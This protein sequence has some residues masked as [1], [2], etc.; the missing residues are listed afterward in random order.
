MKE[1]WQTSSVEEG[2]SWAL[3]LAMLAGPMIAV[4]LLVWLS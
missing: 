4:L 2:A 1:R 3:A